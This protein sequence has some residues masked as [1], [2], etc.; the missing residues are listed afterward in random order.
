[1]KTLSSL[2]FIRLIKEA[3][4]LVPNM[5]DKTYCLL[6]EAWPIKAPTWSGFFKGY[7]Y[8][9]ESMD[10]DD[11][12]RVCEFEWLS[13]HIKEKSA[14]FALPMGTAVID[15]NGGKRHAINFMAVEVS[16]VPALRFYERRDASIS[17]Y[18]EQGK[19][20]EIYT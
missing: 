2:E 4:G 7:K 8:S 20:T 13:R 12:C 9:S 1:M 15:L 11:F 16:G 6:D 17:Q 18:T 19:I 5:M 3:T 10:C 14:G